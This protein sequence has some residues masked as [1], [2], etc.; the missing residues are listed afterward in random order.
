MA[1]ASESRRPAGLEQS[2]SVWNVVTT[3]LPVARMSRRI[4]P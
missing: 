3:G 2:G 4:V 1:S